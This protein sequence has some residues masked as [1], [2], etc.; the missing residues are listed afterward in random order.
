M[1]PAQARL[2]FLAF[3]A[4]SAVIAVN[5]LYLQDGRHPAPL[6]SASASQGPKT[7]QSITPQHQKPKAAPDRKL[8]RAIQRELHYLGYKVGQI[9]GRLGKRTRAA[10]QAYQKAKGLKAD[11]QPSQA[12]LRHILLGPSLSGKPQPSQPIKTV[13]QTSQR[14]RPTSPAKLHREP[15]PK[16]RQ[17]TL[18]PAPARPLQGIERLLAESQPAK[19]ASS[20]P[21]PK[22][23]QSLQRKKADPRVRAVQKVLAELGYAPGR[24]DG[25]LGE[26]T[27]RAIR[28]F[29]RDREMPVTG[30][31]TPALI[32]EIRRITDFVIA[33][34]RN[35][36]N[37]RTR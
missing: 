35:E 6:G 24:I 30:R 13:P 16:A 23:T 4:M 37:T 25:I 15:L 28:A 9:D 2:A 8:V 11:G 12:L 10:I 31:I 3:A 36:T 7:S 14:K 19:T 1:G 21:S 29:E 5:A 22:T 20:D 26:E 27:R 33:S 17:A 32:Q 34:V 18:K